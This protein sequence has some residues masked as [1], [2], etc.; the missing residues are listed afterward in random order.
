MNKFF[1]KKNIILFEKGFFM[2]IFAK[3]NFANLD[4]TSTVIP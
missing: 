2:P 1:A 4:K 3:S